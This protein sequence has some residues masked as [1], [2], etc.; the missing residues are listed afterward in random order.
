MVRSFIPKSSSLN[1]F[2]LNLYRVSQ[3]NPWACSDLEG[4][5]APLSHKYVWLLFARKWTVIDSE[6]LQL[7]LRKNGRVLPGQ[8]NE[9][10]DQTTYFNNLATQVQLLLQAA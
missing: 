6:P 3:V 1:N 4:Q 7:L 8:E 10:E 2:S 9:L 5:R